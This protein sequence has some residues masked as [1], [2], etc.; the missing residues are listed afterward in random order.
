[1]EKNKLRNTV[2][3]QIGIADN[4]KINTKN[5]KAIYIH[6][7]IRDNFPSL[8][9]YNVG[10]IVLDYDLKNGTFSNEKLIDTLPDQSRYCN[11]SIASSDTV[12]YIINNTNKIIK[13]VF[14]SNYDLINKYFIQVPLKKKIC[15]DIK[16]A[17]NGKIYVSFLDMNGNYIDTIVLAIEN[18]ND[19]GPDIAFS[20]KTPLYGKNDKFRG[21]FVLVDRFPNTYGSFRR[22]DFSVISRCK[23]NGVVFTNHSDY[24]WFKSFKYFFGDGDS[25]SF[26]TFTKI[27]VHYYK[28]PGK[29]WVKLQAFNENG[30]WQWYS[31]SIMVL[32][33]PSAYFTNLTTKGCQYIAFEFKDSSNIYYKKQDSTFR[34]Y[35]YFGDGANYAWQTMNM[36]ERRDIQ[37]VYIKDGSYTVTSI[38]S[39]GYCRDTFSRISEVNI[40][41]APKPGMRIAPL[42]GCIPLLVTLTAKYK[43]TVDSTNWSSNN[44][45]NITTLKQGPASFTF[46]SAGKFKLYQQQYGPT[47]C[48]T[49]D[50]AEVTVLQGV[51]RTF[52]PAVINATVEGQDIIVNWKRTPNAE[53]YEVYREGILITT[54]SDSFY[55]DNSVSVNDKSYSYLIVANDI[56]GES[57][58]KSNE[59][60]TILMQAAKDKE[61]FGIIRWTPYMHWSAGV[62]AYE[63]LQINNIQ[64]TESIVFSYNDSSKTMHIDTGFLMNGQYEKCYRIK[65]IEKDGNAAESRSN[66]VCVPYESVIWIPTAITINGDGLNESLKINT[67]GIRSFTIS[68]YNRW[69]GKIFESLSIGDEWKPG[70]EEQGVFMYVVKATTNYGEYITK[71]TVTVLR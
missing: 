31:D 16:L 35:W 71:G 44:G 55:K 60:K 45:H 54:T 17:P 6:N 18:P 20:R 2:P 67:Y 57:T 37:H 9:N 14:N 42:T 10:V 65:A 23:G 21:Q 33:A 52:S 19:A 8:T 4:F 32:T 27:A 66:T 40:L 36:K 29:Y 51:D 50:T 7:G 22:V 68:I 70:S 63:V 59:G 11:L 49:K 48:I 13:Y 41:P 56:C 5:T 43:E 15:R 64:N 28:A 62:Q 24:Y 25:L 3:A 61:N 1:C 34:H 47:G 30:T 12:L 69:G 39:D 53:M 58:L 46:N 38:V 26:D